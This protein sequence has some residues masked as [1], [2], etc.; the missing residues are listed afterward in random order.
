MPIKGLVGLVGSD[1]DK[2]KDKDKDYYNH[3]TCPA[4]IQMN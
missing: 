4:C 1:E 3:W 2:D